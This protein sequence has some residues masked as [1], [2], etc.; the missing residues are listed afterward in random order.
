[1]D[2]GRFR[3]DLYHRLNVIRI[4][5]PPLRGRR[6]DIPL[7]SYYFLKSFAAGGNKTKAAE[8]LGIDRITLWRKL[9]AWDLTRIM[10]A[11]RLPAGRQ[12]R[13]E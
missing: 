3:E 1:M 7:L 11:C 8:L 13:Q 6:E 9:K 4:C 2:E 5:L 10:P 12:G